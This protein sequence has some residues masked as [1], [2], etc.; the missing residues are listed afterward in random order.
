MGY[1]LIVLIFAVPI[2]ILMLVIAK[3]AN[4]LKAL[5]I[6]LGALVVL[7]S[8]FVGDAIRISTQR[9]IDMRNM[10]ARIPQAIEIF[11]QSREQFDILVNSEF[12]Y[13]RVQ[14]ISRQEDV[15][16][17][18]YRFRTVPLDEVVWLSEE[19]REAIIFLK[20]SEELEYNFRLS[21]S[22]FDAPRIV[23]LAELLF[24][25]SEVIL[26][27]HYGMPDRSLTGNDFVDLG[28]GYTLWVRQCQ[29]PGADNNRTYKI[30]AI[31]IIILTTA[32]K[33]GVILL[34]NRK[35]Q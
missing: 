3:Y 35:R 4:N 9:A 6:I 27:I 33:L 29:T 30:T 16:V 10:Q 18:N 28:D 34:A 25:R 22:S 2:V 14:R 32:I 1:F 7:L 24:E 12:A 20:S 17:V 19:E 23:V 26:S 13:N 8:I 31:S 5:A 11:E 21:T 15:W